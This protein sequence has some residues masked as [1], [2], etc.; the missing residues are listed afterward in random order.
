MLESIFIDVGHVGAISGRVVPAALTYSLIEGFIFQ[1][2]IQGVGLALLEVSLKAHAPA[3]VGDTIWAI[4]EI[5]DVRP[6]S[7]AN[8]AVIT[9]EVSV[10]NER[11][12]KILSYSVKRLLA[13]DPA[14]YPATA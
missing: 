13:G 5:T 11:D 1:N 9:S 8:R 4:I 6:S 10:L 2:V 3:R 14:R 12:E 7:K